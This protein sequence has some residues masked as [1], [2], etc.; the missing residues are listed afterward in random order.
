MLKSGRKYLMFF[1]IILIF[2]FINYIL[3]QMLFAFSSGEI[4]HN[5]IKTSRRPWYISP[6]GIALDSEDNLYVGVNNYIMCYDTNGNYISSYYINTLGSYRFMIDKNDNIVV[7]TV[8]SE[9]VNTYNRNGQIIMNEADVNDK[10]YDSIDKQ[11]RY[12]EN[13]SGK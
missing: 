12:I 8:R 7:V 9:K 4:Q 1:S 13:A 11:S 3:I 5:S 10:L 2:I 6:A